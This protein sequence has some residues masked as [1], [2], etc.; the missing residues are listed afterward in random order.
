V[1]QVL[2]FDGKTDE[3][4]ESDAVELL[5]NKGYSV[6][7]IDIDPINVRTPTGLVK[8]FYATAQKYDPYNSLGRA[9]MLNDVY[10]ATQMLE[11]RISAGIN[12]E[13]AYRQCCELIRTL[14]HYQEFLGLT[15]PIVSM[16]IFDHGRLAWLSERLL[17]IYENRNKVLRQLEDDEYHGRLQEA[18][19]LTTVSSEEHEKI[20]ASLDGIFNKLNKR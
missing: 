6:V 12:E 4:R 1:K 14:F 10:Y 13:M 8:Y 16:S 15:T 17:S 18:V 19:A 9:P 2:L 5:R 3:L 7:K 20:V 11:W